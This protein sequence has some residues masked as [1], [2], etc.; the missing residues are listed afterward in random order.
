LDGFDLSIY[1]EAGRYFRHIFG[2][3]VKGSLGLDNIWRGATN[4]NLY[5][6]AGLGLDLHFGK[7]IVFLDLDRLSHQ[8]QH[9][10]DEVSVRLTFGIRG[11][12][13]DLRPFKQRG[14][15]KTD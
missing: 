8:F 10:G 12:S 15:R 4:E 5:F 7:R 13:I 6:G 2:I 1:G 9:R 11:S 3:A 14:V